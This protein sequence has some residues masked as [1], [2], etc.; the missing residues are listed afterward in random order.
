[1]GATEA[2]HAPGGYPEQWRRDEAGIDKDLVFLEDP[3]YSVEIKT[4]SSA[5]NIYGNRSYA[6]ESEAGR[7]D[8]SGY[9]LAVNF[10]KCDQGN[11]TPAITG[12]RFGWLDHSDWMGQKAAT[13]Q[14]A[15]LASAVEA[16]KLLK[17]YGG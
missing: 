4:S 5:G 16:T 2:R 3:S 13:G 17:I 12:I 10:Q 7:K 14:Q 15:R 1:L 9:Y 6:Q 11:P 8:K